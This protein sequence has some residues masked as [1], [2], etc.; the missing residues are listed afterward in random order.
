VSANIM[1]SAA[2]ASASEANM[3][4]PKRNLVALAA[5]TAISTATM[6]LLFWRYPLPTGIATLT[7]LGG[8]F[9]L[10]RTARQLDIV[11]PKVPRRS[12]QNHWA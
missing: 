9:S 12:Q 1:Y 5:I 6:L 2:Q 10:A 11:R 7:A 8:L 3:V 4:E